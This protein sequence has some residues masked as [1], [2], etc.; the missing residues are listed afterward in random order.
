MRTM[1]T[2]NKLSSVIV[3][4]SMV[5]GLFASPFTTYGA[6]VKAQELEPTPTFEPTDIPTE[7]P[8]IVPEEPT[9]IPEEPT[10][11][12]EEPTAIP[13]ETTAIPEEPT[14]EP[15]AIS[16]EPTLVPIEPTQNSDCI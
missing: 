10:V 5:F 12:P 15:T 6:V 8:T 3:M 16:E 4:L 13:E 1:R 7:E 2:L 14:A 9:A 11:I